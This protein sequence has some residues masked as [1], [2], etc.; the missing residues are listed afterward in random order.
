MYAFM[1]SIKWAFIPASITLFENGGLSRASLAFQ[2][3]IF[4]RLSW[5]PQKAP[6]QKGLYVTIHLKKK[7]KVQL[8]YVI[9]CSTLPSCNRIDKVHAVFIFVVVVH[10]HEWSSD[11]YIKRKSERKITYIYI[12]CTRCKGII[13]KYGIAY[14]DTLTISA[15]S[16]K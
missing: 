12:K 14:Q 10:S 2:Q 6:A 13:A 4:C 3:N 5:D 11:A 1:H 7:K 8:C 9:S 16:C 15:K